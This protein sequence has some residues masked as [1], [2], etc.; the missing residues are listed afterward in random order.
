M[1]KTLW[2]KYLVI[3]SSCAFQKKTNEI[4]RIFFFAILDVFL[5][6]DFVKNAVKT[7]RASR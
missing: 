3:S 5:Q 2:F 4:Q 1:E 6:R 7:E